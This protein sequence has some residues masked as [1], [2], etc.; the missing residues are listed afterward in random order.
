M[1]KY[2]EVNILVLWNYMLKYLEIFRGKY[3]EVKQHNVSNLFSQE[4]ENQ[5][6]DIHFG[7]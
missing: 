5:N 7:R 3:L 2:L 1:L 4:S 6:F